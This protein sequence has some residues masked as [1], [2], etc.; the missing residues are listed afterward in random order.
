MNLLP[1]LLVE[2]GWDGKA[3]DISYNH[4]AILLAEG[5]VASPR[6]FLIVLINS[7]GRGWGCKFQELSYEP[8]ASSTSRGWGCKS[9]D[10]TYNSIG[11]S[12]GRGWQLSQDIFYNPPANLLA[13]AA[14]ASPWTLLIILINCNV[15]GWD[16][17][18]LDIPC[19]S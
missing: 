4:P 19:H 13:E 3:L 14:M 12:T 10:L 17:K 6:I 5:G 15:R 18:T 2:V 7:T 9:Q 11:N 1:I 8:L 16:G